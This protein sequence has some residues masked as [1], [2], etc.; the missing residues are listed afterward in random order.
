MFD[1]VDLHCHLLFKIDDGAASETETKELIDISYGSGVRY[2]CFTPHFKLYKFNS[3]DQIVSYNQKIDDTFK[4]VCDYAKEKYPDLKLYLGSEILHHDDIGTSLDSDFCKNL[5]N[6]IYS[7]VEFLPE[8]TSL[9]LE[10]SITKMLK[11]G[12]HPIIAHVERYKTL[13]K[14][15]KLI[16]ALREMGVLIQINSSSILKY[17]F[18]EKARFLKYILKNQ[19]VDIVASDTHS[20]KRS[21]TLSQSA[22][23]VE[24]KYGHEYAK[25]IFYDIPKSVLENN[26]NI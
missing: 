12:F 25:K 4:Y 20:L 22:E 19:L 26:N 16:K 17:K 9:D 13:F 7:L 24:K 21:F 11:L 6:G 1:F 14:N 8:V 3:K 18:G 23:V 15:T 2:I 5:G 10:A